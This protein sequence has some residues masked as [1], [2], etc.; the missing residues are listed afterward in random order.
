M[1]LLF[2]LHLGV[3]DPFLGEIESVRWVC[4]EIVGGLEFS[5]RLYIATVGC[6]GL[7]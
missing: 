6:S 2:V 7:I 4:K 3:C 5:P 1:A